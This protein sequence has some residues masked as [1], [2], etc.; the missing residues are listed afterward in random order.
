MGLSTGMYVEPSS[1]VRSFGTKTV[2]SYAGT[3]G[4]DAVT[5][6]GGISTWTGAWIAGGAEGVP[7]ASP[8]GT[9]MGCSVGVVGAGIESCGDVAGGCGVTAGAFDGDWGVGTGTCGVATEG[10]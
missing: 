1:S 4:R 2:G 7:V 9:T 6:G 3:D 5:A 10:G 8:G